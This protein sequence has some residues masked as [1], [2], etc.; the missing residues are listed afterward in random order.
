MADCSYIVGSNNADVFLRCLFWN[1]CKIFTLFTASIIFLKIIASCFY[2]SAWRRASCFRVVQQHGSESVWLQKME[3]NA[4]AGLP[5]SW[6]W[7]TEAVLD[8]CLAWVWAKCHQW[9]RW[10]VAQ[11]SLSGY[12]CESRKF[13]AFNLTPYNAY[14]ILLIIF[15]NFMNTKRELLCYVQQNCQ[16]RSFV[17][18]KVVEWQL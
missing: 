7:W 13:W 17:F 10:Q 12:S 3:R 15:V 1:K 8:H 14:F 2:A 4:S 18:C 16:F 5:R 11:T 6:C 9:H